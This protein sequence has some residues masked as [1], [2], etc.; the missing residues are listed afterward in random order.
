VE[1]IDLRK[2]IV[3]NLDKQINKELSEFVIPRDIMN[4]KEKLL[5]GKDEDEIFAEAKIAD[6]EFETFINLWLNNAY[7]FREIERAMGML[8]LFYKTGSIEPYISAIE[9]KSA[10]FSQHF[11]QSYGD[12]QVR[13]C[14]LLDSVGLYLA[15][16]FYGIIDA[17]FYFNNVID[18][19]KLKYGDNKRR[20]LDGDPFKL[21]N[22]DDW[23]V[24]LEAK[25]RY[26][27]IKRWRDEVTH[28]FSPLMYML[29]GNDEFDLGKK[30]ILR[31]P[32]LNAE[33]AIEECKKS[34]CLLSLVNIAADTFAVSFINTNSY[35]RNHYHV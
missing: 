27:D 24:L 14:S 1:L 35:H 19:I 12:F 10:D 2:R 18:S 8:L 6:N 7:R 29:D 17:P 21:K 9:N 34:Y 15:F 28:A 30:Q 22:R 13:S 5:N 4:R 25:R 16:V 26:G 3:E 20:I 31:S 32:T 11:W 23:K 33:K